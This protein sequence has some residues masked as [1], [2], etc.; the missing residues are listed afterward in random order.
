MD[1][2]ATWIVGLIATSATSS[3]VTYVTTRAKNLATHDDLD[4]VIEEVRAVTREQESIKADIA[5]ETEE[6]KAKLESGVWDRQKRWEVRRDVILEYLR[7]AGRTDMAL[8]G[9][10]SSL[11]T[12]PAAV[13]KQAEWAV[14]HLRH[15][16]KWLD[17]S[18]ELEGAKGV[19]DV[20]AGK[21]LR[22]ASIRWFALRTSVLTKAREGDTTHY[23]ASIVALQQSSTALY[24]AIR[25]ELGLGEPA[26]S[27][28]VATMPGD[29][30]L[31]D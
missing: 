9:V 21:E 15:M 27:L 8:R 29:T 2:I 28:P 16:D 10:V 3:M 4:K 30:K 17:L 11:M 24:S 19:L 26:E 13:E 1:V 12:K 5:R 31:H 14:H 25:N 23:R 7:C 22:L 20:V 6:I 18:Q